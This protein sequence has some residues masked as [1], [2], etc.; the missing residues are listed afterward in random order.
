MFFKIFG[1][2]IIY[3]HYSGGTSSQDNF[4]QH[5]LDVR[6]SIV[7]EVHGLGYIEGMINDGGA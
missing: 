7:Y 3:I 4:G 5:L 2:E 1:F 6:N